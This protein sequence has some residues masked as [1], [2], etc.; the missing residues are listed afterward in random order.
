MNKEEQALEVLK[1][2]YML[3]L[4]MPHGKVRARNQEALCA[5][6]HAIAKETGHEAQEV[7]DSFESMALQ[8]RMAA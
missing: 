6:L 7:Q 5:L 8:I 3:L 4:Q 1:Q 2:A